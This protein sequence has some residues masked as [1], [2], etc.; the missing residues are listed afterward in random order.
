MGKKTLAVLTALY[1]AC[2]CLL[3]L[4]RH[5]RLQ[6]SIFDLGIFDQA[7]FLVARSDSLFLTTRGL[8]VHGDHFHPILYLLAPI[9][10]LWPSAK[11]LLVLQ[12]IVIAAGAYPAY[13]LGRHFGLGDRWSAVVGA[14]YL[15]HPTVGFLNKFDFHP[16]AVMAPALMFAILFLERAEPI[17][18]LVSILAVLSCTEAAGF[19]V[20][21]LSFTAF[22]VRDR[23]W[24]LGTFVLGAGGILTAKMWMRHFNQG[25]SSPYTMLYTEYGTSETEIAGY[26]LT[27]P[28]E[29]LTR[30]ATPLNLEYL[31]YLFIPL[32]FLPL[33]A[34]ER[35]VPAV[36]VLLGNLLSWRY[37]QHRVEYH[38]GAVLGPIFVWAAVVGWERARKKGVPR[39]T[40]GGFLVVACALA[41]FF[42]PLGPKHVSRLN[43][44]ANIEQAVRQVRPE[45]TVVADNALGAHFSGREDIYLFPNP[46]VTAAWGSRARSL[47]QQSSAEYRPLRRGAVRRGIEAVKVDSIVLPVDQE[48]ISHFPLYVADSLMA[49]REVLRSSVFERVQPVEGEAF[50][51]RRR[52]E[53]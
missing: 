21:A 14:L 32:L 5:Q 41:V 34:P 4:E 37:H 31:F 29:S 47:L 25:Q 19:T 12:T 45:E 13:L 36:P 17:P 1:V 15:V 52:A 20:I 39:E 48:R 53:P 2:F 51:L 8:H 50:V 16:V 35:L 24:F 27:S 6:T 49:R 38:Y 23:W 30:L 43:E 28:L 18:Y 33:L 40:L 11:A 7:C 9:Y 10:L 42:G 46:F 26:L 44:R 22:L 3:T